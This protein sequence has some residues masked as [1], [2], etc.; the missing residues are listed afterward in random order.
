MQVA[1]ELGLT[2]LCKAL[3]YHKSNKVFTCSDEAP[4]CKILLTCLRQTQPAKKLFPFLVL[5]IWLGCWFFFFS[6]IW[7]EFLFIVNRK[8][9]V[10]LTALLYIAGSWNS[11]SCAATFPGVKHLFCTQLLSFDKRKSPLPFFSWARE[12]NSS[13]STQKAKGGKKIPLW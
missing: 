2:V 8:C 9:F 10:W 6:L 5:N 1:K 12:Q 3:C 4:N 13:K 11:C 7:I